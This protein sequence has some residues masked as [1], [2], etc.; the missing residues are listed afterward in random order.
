MKY[1][2]YYHVF[3]TTFHVIL[4]KIDFV[5]DSVLYKM[6][7]F[8]YEECRKTEAITMCH[9]H[10]CLEIMGTSLLLLNAEVFLEDLQKCVHRRR[11]YLEDKANGVTSDWGTESLPR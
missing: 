7:K 6:L 2:A 1:S 3:P 10:F 9:T 11:I 8:Y 5:W 4:R